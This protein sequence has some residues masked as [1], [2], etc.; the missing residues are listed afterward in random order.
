[1]TQSVAQVD[2]RQNHDAAIISVAVIF[3]L[4]GLLAVIGRIASKRLKQNPIAADDFLLMA[5]WVRALRLPQ[6]QYFMPKL[7]LG[8]SFVEYKPNIASWQG[9][10]L[11]CPTS[12]RA[13]RHPRWPQVRLIPRFNS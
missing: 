1:M 10:A 3:S 4:L 7:K 13:E 8:S 2:L 12:L 11:F 9:G 6:T 5:S